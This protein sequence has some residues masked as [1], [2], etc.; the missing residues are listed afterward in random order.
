MGQRGKAPFPFLGC[1]ME[2]LNWAIS[3]RIRVTAHKEAANKLIKSENR[4]NKHW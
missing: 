3:E 1:C 4:E 2:Q